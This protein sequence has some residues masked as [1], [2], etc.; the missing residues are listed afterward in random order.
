MKEKGPRKVRIPT[1]RIPKD[2]TPEEIKKITKKFLKELKAGKIP[3]VYTSFQ[4]RE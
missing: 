1:L 3:G 2:A 4:E